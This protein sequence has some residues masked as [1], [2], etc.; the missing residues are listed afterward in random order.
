MDRSFGCFVVG[1][2]FTFL[3]RFIEGFFFLGTKWKFGKIQ[4]DIRHPKGVVNGNKALGDN[5]NCNITASEEISVILKAKINKNDS[6]D[7]QL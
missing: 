1:D 2:L 4:S 5:K 6:V 3:N 7:S